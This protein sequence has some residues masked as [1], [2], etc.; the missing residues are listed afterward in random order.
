MCTLFTDEKTLVHSVSIKKMIYFK[1]L[2]PL[3]LFCEDLRYFRFVFC[4]LSTNQT[5]RRPLPKVPEDVYKM[6][7]KN[8]VSFVF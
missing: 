3:V 5:K 8:S 2:F 7:I 4:L 1:Y 6:M